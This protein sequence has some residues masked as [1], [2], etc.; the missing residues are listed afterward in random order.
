MGGEDLSQ[1]KAH[2]LVGK[3]VAMVPEGRG[4]FAKLTVLENLEMGAFHRTDKE[5]IASDLEKSTNYFPVWQ[6]ERNNSPAR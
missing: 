5:G 1:Y 2:H 4:V 6:N 3:G